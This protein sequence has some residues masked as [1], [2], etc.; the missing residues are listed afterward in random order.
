MSKGLGLIEYSLT[1]ALI[2]AVSITGLLLIGNN[3]SNLLS[4]LRSNLQSHSA[5]AEKTR[6]MLSMPPSSLSLKKQDGTSASSN[7]ISTPKT[8]V[9]IKTAATSAQKTQT[10]VCFDT[11]CLYVPTVKAGPVE[12]VNGALGGELVTSLSDVIQQIAD[13]IK[14]DPSAD[15]S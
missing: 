6:L 3:V 5:V 2:L 11:K 15:P 10:L 14:Q 13:T 7:T 9:S 12:S 1:A 4:N 8:T